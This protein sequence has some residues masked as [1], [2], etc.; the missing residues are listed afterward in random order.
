LVRGQI[1][2][3]YPDAVFLAL[4]STEAPGKKPKFSTTAAKILFHAHL[5]PDILLVGFDLSAEQIKNEPWWFVIAEN[6]S[7]P[8]FGLDL[9]I[10]DAPPVERDPNA[11]DGEP[12]RPAAALSRRAPSRI[13][14]GLRWGDLGLRYQRFLSTKTD[15]PIVDEDSQNNRTS[16]TWPTNGAVIA[17]T[18]LQNPVRAAF[19]GQDLVGSLL[20]R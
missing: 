1:V 17:R 9:P 10:G 7:A 8:R 12:D 15:V 5:P 3:R 14:N 20:K 13:R 19:N 4:Q 2:Q 18:L 11:P 16:T 6:P